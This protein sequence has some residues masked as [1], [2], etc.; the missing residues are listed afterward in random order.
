[1]QQLEGRLARAGSLQ[2][3][4][5]YLSHAR[6]GHT[7]HVVPVKPKW[8]SKT[9]KR[10]MELNGN[11]DHASNRFDFVLQEGVVV[12]LGHR[13]EIRADDAF[14]SLSYMEKT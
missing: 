10:L 6:G 3:T 4:V 13:Y 5:R 1:M 9:E 14:Q 11:K 12:F 2:S 7:T 8:I